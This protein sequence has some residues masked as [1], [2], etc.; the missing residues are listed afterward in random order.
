MHTILYTRDDIEALVA[1]WDS[2][3]SMESVEARTDLTRARATLP[4]MQR[5]ALHYLCQGY[6][7]NDIAREMGMTTYAARQLINDT[8]ARLVRKMN[9]GS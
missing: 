8:F 1:S 2:G 4:E 6:K 9:R 3:L 7:P 5:L